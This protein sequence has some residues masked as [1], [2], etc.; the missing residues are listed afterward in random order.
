[1]AEGGFASFDSSTNDDT[2]DDKISNMAE[3]G[4]ASFDS[5]TNDDTGDDSSVPSCRSFSICKEE[6]GKAGTQKLFRS[7]GVT[8]F[9]EK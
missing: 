2:G 5:S 7:T 9:G 3:G 4:F 6:R 1:M 8:T